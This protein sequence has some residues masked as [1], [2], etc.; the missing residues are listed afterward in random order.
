MSTSAQPAPRRPIWL[1]V[2]LAVLVLAGI[3]VLSS[4]VDV[5]RV[6]LFLQRWPGWA[7]FGVLVVLPLC[8]FPVS[9]LHV[10]AGIRWGPVLGIS[11]VSLSILLQLLASYGLVH[12]F[13]ASFARRFE[14]LRRGLPQGAYGPVTLFTLLLPGVPYFA[15][16]YVLPLAGVPLRTYLLW[17]LPL[18]ILRS[19]VAVFF[20][21]ESDRLTPARIA[22]FVA[23]G[24]AITLSCA[25][26]FRRLRVAVA[27][28]PPEANGP[29]PL[30]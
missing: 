1:T 29:R 26:A 27:N 15:K 5:H 3:A 7:V 14:S 18:H 30:A 9:V 13:R 20:G 25:W 24:I 19:A 21:H 28:R 10:V 6:H 8:G 11:L 4:F 2:G 12:L 22:G 17:A 23:Y 16:N